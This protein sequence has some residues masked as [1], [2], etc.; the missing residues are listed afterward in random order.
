MKNDG[1]DGNEL[2]EKA[3]SIARKRNLIFSYE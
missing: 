1:N 2:T 3:L